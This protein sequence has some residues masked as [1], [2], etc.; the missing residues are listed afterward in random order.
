MTQEDGA[1]QKGFVESLERGLDDLPQEERERLYR[2]CAVACAQGYVLSEQQRRFAECGGDID[3]QFEKYART[4][5]FFSDI[6]ERGRVYEV[7]YPRCLC[8]LVETGLTS[9]PAHCECSRQSI[10]FVMESLL[11]GKMIRVET[12]HTV[13]SGADECRFRVT[14]E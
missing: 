3:R 1:F 6:I 12:L 9:L 13:L 14:V 10:L 4:D 8:P 5:F 2:G 11:P 7:G